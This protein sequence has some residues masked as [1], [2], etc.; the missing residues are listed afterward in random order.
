MSV[1]SKK[2]KKKGAKEDLL[3]CAGKKSE[4]MW[5]QDLDSSL[6][7]P[8]REQGGEVWKRVC[9]AGREHPHAVSCGAL[10]SGLPLALGTHEEVMGL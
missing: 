2:K 7:P 4:M 9:G 1:I 5:G 3:T 6:I 8:H 10:S